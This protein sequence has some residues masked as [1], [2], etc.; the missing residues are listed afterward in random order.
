MYLKIHAKIK[1]CSHRVIIFFL[2]EDIVEQLK[3]DIKEIEPQLEKLQEDLKEKETE[4]KKI[5][6]ANEREEAKLQDKREKVVKK[7]R[8]SDYNTY[9]RIRKARSG[10]A[11]ATVSRGA[12][13]G[14]HNVVP[15]QRQIEI[16][17]SKRLYTCESCG[18]LLV[19]ADIA[20]DVESKQK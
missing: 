3:M 2:V 9:M 10:K 5:I 8:K 7:V 12:C 15:P 1:T 4:L 18:R 19:A 17:Q 6:K 11:I 14:C 16:R 13:T 20:D